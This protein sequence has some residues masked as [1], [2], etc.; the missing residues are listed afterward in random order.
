MTPDALKNLV[1]A[2]PFRAFTLHTVDGRS[3]PVP[4]PDFISISPTGRAAVVPTD[5][6]KFEIIQVSQIAEATIEKGSKA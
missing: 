2:A 4:H 3:V 5:G 1:Y 6:E